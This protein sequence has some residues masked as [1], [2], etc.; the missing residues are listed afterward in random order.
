M[1]YVSKHGQKLRVHD[2]ESDQSCH[3]T[4]VLKPLAYIIFHNATL[5]QS[6]S[7]SSYSGRKE[8]GIMDDSKYAKWLC[9]YD[10]KG[11]LNLLNVLL[12]VCDLRGLPVSPL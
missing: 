11:F 4:T 12:H 6:L 9:E 3:W 7:R 10:K 1:I 5:I 8:L 2:H